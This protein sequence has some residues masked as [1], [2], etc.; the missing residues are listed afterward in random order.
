MPYRHAEAEFGD[1][2]TVV[3]Q[4]PYERQRLAELGLRFR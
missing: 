1:G 4:L 2:G 3:G